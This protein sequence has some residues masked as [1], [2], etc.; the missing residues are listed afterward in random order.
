MKAEYRHADER[1]VER[2]GR[3]LFLAFLKPVI[4]G[5]GFYF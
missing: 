5:E 2:E 1:F 3:L 4:N